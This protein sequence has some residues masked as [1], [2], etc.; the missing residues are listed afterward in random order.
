M[1]HILKFTL[2]ILVNFSIFSQ[3]DKENSN[4]LLS[5]GKPTHPNIDINEKSLYLGLEYRKDLG[6]FFSYGFFVL[7]SFENSQLDFFENRERMLLYLNSNDLTRGIATSWTSVET[8]G[9][10]GK[11]HLNFINNTNHFLS[12]NIGLGYY[13][14]NSEDQSLNEVTEVSTFTEEGEFIESTI[15]DFS[16][17]TSSSNKS[18]VFILPGLEYQYFFSSNLIIGFEF[19]LLLDLNPGEGQVDPVF[20]NFY[21]FNMKFGKRF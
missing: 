18:E 9:F 1:R 8:Y 6:R 15:T 5:I 21:S 16:G 2:F 14:S 20:A 3:I 7:R 10:G 11:A 13:V 19:N 4:L 17:L 12:L